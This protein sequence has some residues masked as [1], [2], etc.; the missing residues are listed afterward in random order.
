MME[1]RRGGRLDGVA[2]R[3][4]SGRDGVAFGVAGGGIFERSAAALAS[5]GSSA[6]RLRSGKAVA[7]VKSR[8]REESPGDW[9]ARLSRSNHWS[10]ASAPQP[11][12]RIDDGHRAV[13]MVGTDRPTDP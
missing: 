5:S 10:T 12:H 13:Q 2:S 11:D 8:G 9:V 4:T 3:S 6:H 7:T 1:R